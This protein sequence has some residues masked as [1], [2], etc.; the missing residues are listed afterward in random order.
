MSWVSSGRSRTRLLRLLSSAGA[1]LLTLSVLVSVSC[2][3]RTER[4]GPDPSGSGGAG[5]AGAAGETGAA[6][7][8]GAGEGGNWSGPATGEAC[9]VSDVESCG[10]EDDLCC[11]RAGGAKCVPSSLQDCGACGIA[12]NTATASA[13]V[14]GECACGD[15]PACTGQAPYCFLQ[16]CVQCRKDDDCTKPGLTQCVEGA[17]QQCDPAENTGC[18]GYA[19]ACNEDGICVRCSEKHPCPAP[20]YCDIEDSRCKGCAEHH[21]CGFANAPICIVID[22]VF[23]ECQACESDE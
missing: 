10:S 4:K 5:E 2:S 20:L 19:A 7:A 12:C 16:H 3:G 6:G 13:C 1:S 15:E 21:D 22:D 8:D 14:D 11:A 23:S 17:C 9:D 18:S